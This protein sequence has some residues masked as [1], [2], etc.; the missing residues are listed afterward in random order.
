MEAYFLMAKYDSANR[1][2]VPFEN[3]VNY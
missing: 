3:T 2:L 1:Y